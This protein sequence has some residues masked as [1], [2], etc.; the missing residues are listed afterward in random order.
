MNEE[1][2][3]PLPES[4]MRAHFQHINV[5]NLSHQVFFFS[6]AL[7]CIFNALPQ[8]GSHMPHAGGGGDDRPLQKDPDSV[9]FSLFYLLAH[10]PDLLSYLVVLFAHEMP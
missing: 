10:Y 6:F 2:T 9:L 3:E 5:S 4:D 7:I 1:T 8:A